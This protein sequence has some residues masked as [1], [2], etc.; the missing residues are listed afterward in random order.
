MNVRQI[1]ESLGQTQEGLAA[2]AGLDRSYI[3]GIE[4]GERNP[5]LSTI[6]QLALALRVRPAQL[7][8]K[9]GEN[10]Y[11][12]Q[13]RT[14]GVQAVE[15]ADGL[16]I[17][18]RYDSYDAKYTLTAA[19]RQQ[20]RSVLNVLKD[21]LAKGRGKSDAVVKTF[22]AATRSWPH[23]NPSDLWTFLINRA[24]CDL[25]NHPASNARLNLEQ[26]WKR[27]SGWAL[28]RIL[29]EHYGQFL[30]RSGITVKVGSKA[31]KTSLLGRIGDSRIVPDKADLMLTYNSDD[32]EK[33]LGV[34]HVKASIAERRT[35]DVPMSQALMEAGYISVFCT[36]DT[37]SFPSPEPVNRGEFGEADGDRI[38]DKRRDFEEHGHFS[39]CFSYNQNT[40]PTLPDINASSRIYVCDFTNPDDSFARFLIDTLSLHST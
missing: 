26:S 36:M 37:K 21:G 23:A 17:R 32:E 4:R 3:G 7:F 28:E 20:Y 11:A 10:N 16:I 2:D 29:V 5:S 12:V 1:R 40:L 25:S 35:D 34:V 27:T 15:T 9:I 38:S 31:D 33:L 22:L 13:D 39:V 24:Y 8:S 6:L 14:P 19:T 18:F 30:E